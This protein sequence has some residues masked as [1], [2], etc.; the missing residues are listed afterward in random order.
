MLYTMCAY[1]RVC[2][3]VCVCARE[4]TQFI[5]ERHWVNYVRLGLRELL[6]LCT[7]LEFA[8][9]LA[10]LHDYRRLLLLLGSQMF[11]RFVGMTS[12]QRF[13]FN[14]VALHYDTYQ[15]VIKK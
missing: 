7:A 15:S 9:D 1:I 12:F 3:R 2:A 10:V 6:H 11:P 13:R 14:V 8:V 4:C 5:N